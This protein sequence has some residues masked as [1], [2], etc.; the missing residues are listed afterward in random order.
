MNIRRTVSKGVD[1]WRVAIAVVLAAAPA[2]VAYDDDDDLIV[3]QVIV[4]LEPGESIEAI[5]ADYGTTLLDAIPSRSIY[6]LQLPEAMSEEAFEATIEEDPRVEDAELVYALSVRTEGGSQGF[7][8][9]ALPATPID[10]DEQYAWGRVRLPLSPTGGG[11]V[12]AVIDTGLD[13][14][15]PAFGAVAIAP[16]WDFVDE[17][18]D[19]ADAGNG[20]DD[21]ADG[22]IDEMV[23]H[24][25]HLAS[26]VARLAPG[27]TILPL[28]VLDSDGT[29]PSFRV[30]RAVYHAVDAG[31]HV[32]NLSLGTE[33]D[34]EALKDAMEY[35][36]A[37][38][39][40]VVAAAG[41][42]DAAEPELY[43]AGHASVVAVAS[44]DAADLKSS[45]SSY[46]NSIAITAPGSAIAG[47][48]PG[49]DY[50]FAD[51]TSM[52]AAIVSGAA[53]LVRADD[54]AL[55]APGV[56]LRLCEA[57]FDIDALNP[58]YAN[59]LGCGRLDV[60][61]AIGAPGDVDG[62][63]TVG[64]ADLLAL[65]AA[66]GT[67]APNADLDRDGAVGFLDLL[68]LLA[69]WT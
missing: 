67:A 21:D 54:A 4:E 17:D 37:H 38:D 28:R 35:A 56:R 20:A 43:P 66:W 18:A 48:V 11:V 33:R 52:A 8:F 34:L 27:T 40:V 53:A 29:S 61:A 6:L 12:V 15:H 7:F 16:G 64:F 44:T 14:T 45:F 10:F 26:L 32:V 5:N 49:G 57:A 19:P 50:V 24:G 69:A 23:G 13:P 55:S 62:D 46:G 51:G 41:N 68:L 30:A 47:A 63:G 39:V 1:G 22:V 31:A 2:A 3:D 65:L 59:L 42:L 25:T 36:A 58:P 60:A 9:D